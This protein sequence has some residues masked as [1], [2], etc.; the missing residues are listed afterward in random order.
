LC[1]LQ[2]NRENITSIYENAPG[3]TVIIIPDSHYKDITISN[4]LAVSKAGITIESDCK[5]VTYSLPFW[6]I[7][8][9]LLTLL[10]MLAKRQYYTI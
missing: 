7:L 1:P 5:H 3:G 8:A 6:S 9:L 10:R 4:D 2:L